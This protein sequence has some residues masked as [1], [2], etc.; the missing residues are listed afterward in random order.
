MPIS[1]TFVNREKS[2]DDKGRF[3]PG[4]PGGSGRGN[5]RKR[6]EISEVI[7]SIK[8]L[9]Q[10]N[11]V[12]LLDP[13]VLDL[14]GR[15]ILHDATSKDKK[16]RFDS[17]K[18]FLNWLSK[19]IEAEQREKQQNSVKSG[20]IERLQDAI[21]LRQEMDIYGVKEITDLL[22]FKCKK[23]LGIDDEG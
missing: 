10:N 4:N 13:E 19:R 16:T 23:K 15:L 6:Q 12:S 20:E 21:Q 3:L 14:I 11:D 8:E 22:C 9:S 2:R 17:V 18:Q 1:D 5:T 7:D